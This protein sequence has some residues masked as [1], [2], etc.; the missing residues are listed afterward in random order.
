MKNRPLY[1]LDKK[2]N[3]NRQPKSGKIKVSGRILVE[4]KANLM[5]AVPVKVELAPKY[6]GTAA[7][8]KGAMRT[9]PKRREGSHA[10]TFFLDVWKVSGEI[11]TQST[12]AIVVPTK[13]TALKE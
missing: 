4:S 1:S 11:I 8:M 13:T 9:A 10:K 12:V 5:S 2:K 7:T 6:A 3:R